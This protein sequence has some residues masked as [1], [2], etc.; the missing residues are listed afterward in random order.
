MDELLETVRQMLV[1]LSQKND[2]RVNLKEQLIDAFEL[3]CILNVGD[4]KFTTM[5]KLFKTYELDKKPY[6]LQYE[7]LEVIQKHQL[8]TSKNTDSSPS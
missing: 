2:Q 8:I 4:T 1:L 5:K 7:V 3:K 6:Y